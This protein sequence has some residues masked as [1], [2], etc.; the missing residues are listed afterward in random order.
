ME[1]E[2]I[3]NRTKSVAYCHIGGFPVAVSGVKVVR[4]LLLYFRS[5][6][7]T[8]NKKSRSRANSSAGGNLARCQ[9]CPGGNRTMGTKLFLLLR[10]NQK[11]RTTW[12]RMIVDKERVRNSSSFQTSLNGYFRVMCPMPGSLVS[13]MS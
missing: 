8:V 1:R 3:L 7:T 13:L 2:N 9:E 11:E 12:S 5:E 10:S 6:Q 4:E